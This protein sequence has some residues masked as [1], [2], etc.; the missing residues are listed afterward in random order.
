MDKTKCKRCGG[1]GV[2]DDGVEDTDCPDCDGSGFEGEDVE[3]EHVGPT[4][5]LGNTVT[6]KTTT[7]TCGS[8]NRIVRVPGPTGIFKPMGMVRPFL[9]D[10]NR[11][12]PLRRHKA[13]KT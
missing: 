5:T 11:I 2:I 10:M 13:K 8:K 1:L 9:L 3:A 6:L 12:F 7:V 4:V